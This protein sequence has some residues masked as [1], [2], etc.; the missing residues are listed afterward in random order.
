[1]L[2]HDEGAYLD[3]SSLLCLDVAL[4]CFVAAGTLGREKKQNKL[5]DLSLYLS[6]S[7][8]CSCYGVWNVFLI[9]FERQR[10]GRDC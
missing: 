7:L 6:F 4:L 8:G 3:S 1:M 9:T 2:R 5:F 10:V